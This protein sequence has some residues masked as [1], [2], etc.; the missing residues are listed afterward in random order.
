MMMKL[1]LV[2]EEPSSCRNL[3]FSHILFSD[4]ELVNF[5]VPGLIRSE[6]PVASPIQSDKNL[7]FLF[8]S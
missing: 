6:L 1:C 8:A 7:I 5:Y 4:Q 3:L 2:L